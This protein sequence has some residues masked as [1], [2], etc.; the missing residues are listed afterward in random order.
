MQR[1]CYLAVGKL[2]RRPQRAIYALPNLHQVRSA[3]VC[4]HRNF[5]V[6]LTLTE[7]TGSVTLQEALEMLYMEKRLPP[8]LSEF[9]TMLLIQAIIRQAREAAHQSPLSLWSPSSAVQT[10]PRMSGDDETRRKSIS[11]SR[12]RNCACDCLDIVHWSAN[13]K[14]AGRAG[15]EHP[16]I[17]QLHLSRLI[18]LA[19]MVHIQT[20]VAVSISRENGEH[21]TGSTGRLAVARTQVLQWALHDQHKARLCLVHAG[22]LFWHL[23]RYS[24]DSVFEPFAIYMATLVVWAY[25]VS[26]DL[27]RHRRM[28]PARPPAVPE[29]RADTSG[30][31]TD[32]LGSVAAECGKASPEA[33][34]TPEPSFIQLDRPCDD[35]LVQTYIRQGDKMSGYMLHVGDISDKGAPRKIL[36]EGIRLLLG[37]RDGLS[38]EATDRE[39]GNPEVQEPEC[40]WGIER[41]H[42][43]ILARMADA[44][45]L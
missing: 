24:L 44:T 12:W 41:Q 13:S 35:E 2:G 18:L 10:R 11:A 17:L 5:N 20:L 8:R 15:W 21:E 27:L 29:T 19:P 39:G 31:A 37:A 43:E 45:I 33:E 32:T 34:D 14:V 23:R 9:A 1:A 25:S 38:P 28:P 30:A 36:R 7:G 42:A 26:M 3:F 4:S 16:T 6:A 22:S 40:A